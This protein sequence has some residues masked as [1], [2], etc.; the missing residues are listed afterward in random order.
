VFP[1]KILIASMCGLA[2]V[3]VAV[4]QQSSDQKQPQVKVNMINV[5]SPTPEDQKE[6]S[7]A[8][9]RVPKP[10]SGKD[11]FGKDY[12]VARGHS[13]LD[14]KV[15]VLGMESLPAGASSGANW[16][17]MRREYPDAAA[18]STVQYSLSVDESNM[19]ETLV[20]R[21]RDPKELM[22]VS[23]ED[24]ASAVASAAPMVSSNTPA[25]RVKLERFGKSSVVLARCAGT[26]GQPVPDQKAYEPI[27]R[28]ASDILNCYRD[29]MGIRKIV[30]QELE[31]I[32]ETSQKANA[33]K[34]KP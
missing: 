6:L 18:F 16:V 31:R 27:C 25:S 17:R 2:A 4:G 15:P 9:A 28:A 19:V 7:A 34:K 22:E 20:F 1:T 13:T 29:V 32:G 10:V 11:Y 21:V 3:N 8:L 14:P 23:I 33:A 12:E 26:E 24:N 5:C 30:P